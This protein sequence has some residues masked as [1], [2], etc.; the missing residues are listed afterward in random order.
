[1]GPLAGVKIVEMAGV[2]PVPFAGMLLADMG[3]DVVRIDRKPVGKGDAFDALAGG[4]RLDR[5]R[6]SIAL[7][8]KKPDALAVALELAAGADAL[9]EG[10]RPGVMERL[11]LGPD[12]CLARNPR[13]VYGRVTG[14]GQEGPLAA[15]AGHDIDY[16]ALTGALHAI[17]GREAPVPPL[18][19]LGDFGGGA[20]FLAFGIVCALVEARGSGRGQVVDAAMTDGVGLLMAMTYKLK[21]QGL[22]R[23]ERQA[24][25][26]DGG[27][28]FYGVYRCADGKWVAV[29]AL[30]PQFFAALV[31]K[32]GFEA[33][34]FADRWDP[35]VWP[36]MRARLEAAFAQ[37]PRD[38]WTTLFGD[39]DACVA[40]V[41]DL[42][43]APRHP[44]NLARRAFVEVDGAPQ[45]A[46]APRF[47][48]TPAEIGRPPARQ[49][50]H[51]EAILRERGF[52]AAQIEALKRA[53]AL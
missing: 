10:F 53:G 41:L 49:G 2:G 23:G 52:S 5:G 40:P 46:P 31:E 1:M 18:N 50:E 33:G 12:V 21:A 34:A 7:D 11:G 9:I 28:P 22:W 4:A 16:I 25:A 37:R 15:T 51:G 36:A 39:S 26:L 14:W 20:M 32:L 27:A 24:N 43:E 44:H 6:R 13:L 48:R 30:E 38:E 42:D 47:S 45:P 35:R 19:L 3:A 29:G 8:L 17:G